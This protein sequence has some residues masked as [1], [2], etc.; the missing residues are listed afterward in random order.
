MSNNKTDLKEKLRLALT[1]TAKVISEDYKVKDKSKE[2]DLNAKESNFFEIDNLSN[3]NDF[4]KLRAEF[5]S[6]A[7]KKKIF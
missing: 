3:R 1:S 5:D 7:L 2:K 6:Q 4:I